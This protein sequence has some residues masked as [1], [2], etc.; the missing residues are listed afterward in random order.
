MF[1]ASRTYL[2]NEWILFKSLFFIC[3]FW[4]LHSTFL[5]SFF[6]FN[7][8]LLQFFFFVKKGP[9]QETECGLCFFS[10][11]FSYFVR[12]QNHF[13][14][15]R[16]SWLFL[17][18]WSSFF[19]RGRFFL[20]GTVLRSFFLFLYFLFL[21]VC[22][23]KTTLHTSNKDKKMFTIFDSNQMIRIPVPSKLGLNRVQIRKY[24]N[25]THN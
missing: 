8:S 4:Q 18:W 5:K 9:F 13:I 12:T 25:K 19:F 2:W 17:W 10:R 22:L 23:D 21:F 15:W 3:W 20:T 7:F 24:K 6:S 11:F 14:F 16:P 1:F